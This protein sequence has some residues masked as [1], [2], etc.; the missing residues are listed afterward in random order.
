MIAVFSAFLV[1]LL[2]PGPA[3]TVEGRLTLNKQPITLKA[4]YA[5]LQDNAEKIPGQSKTLRILLVDREVPEDSLVG[6]AFPPIWDLA[7]EGSV[8]GLLIEMNPADSQN[9]TIVLLDKPSQPGASLTTLTKSRSG[10]KL[11]KEWR[12]SDDRVRGA[13]D[14]GEEESKEGSLPSAVFSV[15]FDAPVTREPLISADLKGTA[16]LQSPQVAALR[17]KIDA[18]GRGDLAAIRSVSSKRANRRL[19]RMPPEA[20]KQLKSMGKQIAAEQRKSLSKVQ[21]VIVRGNRATVILTK[22]ESATL[23]KEDSKW[24][25]DD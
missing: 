22:N 4:A 8:R 6:N 24:K 25:T 16:A 23:V 9:I 21:R 17:A 15:R 1:A 10:Q 12:L 19:D 13:L 11:F 14:H 18:V 3:G 7:M 2:F 20:F 5:H